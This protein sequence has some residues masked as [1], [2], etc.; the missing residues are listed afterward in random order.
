MA[1]QQ[2]FLPSVD[3]M[4]NRKIFHFFILKVTLGLCPNPHQEPEVLGTPTLPDLSRREAKKG[5]G[6]N[7]PAREGAGPIVSP[8]IKKNV[9]FKAGC[10]ASYD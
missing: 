5:S 2:L 6:D 10:E 3:N 4:N 8:I 9:S 1:L 7:R